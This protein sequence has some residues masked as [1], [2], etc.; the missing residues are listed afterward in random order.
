MNYNEEM[1]LGYLGEI[2]LIARLLQHRA[3]SVARVRCIRRKNQRREMG[4]T[5]DPIGLSQLQGPNGKQ[6]KEKE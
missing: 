6:K 1:T 4:K 3:L 2:D 5:F